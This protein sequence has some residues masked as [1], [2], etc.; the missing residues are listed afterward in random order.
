[1]LAAYTGIAI[2]QIFKRPPAERDTLLASS[3][4]AGLSA[5]FGAP[6]AGV[7]F[8]IEEMRAAITPMSIACAMAASMAADLVAGHFF[9][10]QPVYRFRSIT[11]MPVKFFLW[12]ILL[13]IICAL[14]GDLFKRLLYSSDDFFKFFRIPGLLRPIFPVMLS[15]PLSFYLWDV[16]GGGHPLID[17]LSTVN[18]PI[19][20]LLLILGVNLVYSSFC[21]GSGASGGIFLPL[22]TCG[23]LAGDTFG[24]ILTEATLVGADYQLNFMILG[25]AAMF[26]AVVKVP[27][28]GI[29]LVLEMTA[30]Y[31]HLAS[32]VL[33]SLCSFVTSELIN[34]PPVY[35]VLLDRI[36][37][38]QPAP[39]NA[40]RQH[41]RSGL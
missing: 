9:G 12:I 11:V 10:L 38:G 8:M 31:N 5:A 27:V 15:I 17:S 19:N 36:L 6:L 29:V 2:L 1:M 26:S 7:L 21:A 35:D 3:T 22:I 18:R 37:A 25:M 39:H 20:M 23:A 14:L 40:S 34:S 32:L 16:T 4:A 13:G 30:N 41:T 24:R 33:V 28:T